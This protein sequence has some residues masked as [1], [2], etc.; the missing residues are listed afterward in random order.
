MDKRLIFPGNSGKE[1]DLFFVREDKNYLQKHAAAYHPKVAEYINQA[2][3]MDDLIQVLLT[4][5]GA[6]EYWGQNINSDFFP[7]VPLSHEGSDYGYQTFK[8]NAHF[9]N[10]HIN[11]NPALA[12]GKVLH[13]VWNDGMKRVEL[14][15]GINPKL[16]SD[17]ADAIDRGE[18]LCFS[19]GCKVPYDVC[20]I[21]GNR[22]K[23]RAEYCDHLRYQMGQVD[24]ITGRQVYAV[25]TLPRFFDISRVLI[26]ADKTAYM[27]TKV[28]SAANPY[29]SF[30]SAELAS[31]PLGKIADLSYLSKV[32]EERI[33][34]KA[35]SVKKNAEITKRIELP[36]QQPKIVTTMERTIPIADR[37]LEATSPT[38]PANLLAGVDPAKLLSTFLF[39]AMAPKKEEISSSSSDISIENFDPELAKRLLPFVAERS[40]ARPVLCRRIVILAKKLEDHDPATIKT[41]QSIAELSSEEANRKSSAPSAGT[42]AGVIAALY[43]IFGPHMPVLRLGGQLMSEYPFLAVALGAGALQAA[44]TLQGPAKSGIYSIDDPNQ[45][46]YNIGWQSR[47]ARQQARPVAV[48]KTGAAE[49]KIDSA[50]ARKVYYG[51]PAIWLGSKALKAKQDIEQTQGKQPGAVSRFISDNPELI[52][53]GLIAEHLSG[54]PV[55][56]RISSLLE[57]GKRITKHASIQNLDFLTSLPESEQD[58]VWDLAILDAA[59]RIERKLVG[60]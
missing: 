13:A 10:H 53:G 3:P 5:L 47:F 15:V 31:L 45:G 43:A 18:N 36:A 28:A 41:A 44:R 21:C 16:D 59:S 27:W 29:K 26:P 57:S 49:H 32:A 51:L 54:K 46:L 58:L 50:L 8:T 17:A 38:I 19:M 1:R 35:A 37:L 34:H 11:K 48:I 14:I 60:G 23:T 40:Y 20:N 7:Q 42:V 39:L 52:G 4:A 25:N 33:P 22:A 6:G 55:S 56:K 9:F 2:K 30:S 12:K 24:P